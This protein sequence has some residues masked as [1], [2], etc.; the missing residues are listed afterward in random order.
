M[1]APVVIERTSVGLGV[2]A[3]SDA[4]AA[5]DGVTGELFQATLQPT[6]RLLE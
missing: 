4:A 3:R 1:E 5:V 2:H 6:R